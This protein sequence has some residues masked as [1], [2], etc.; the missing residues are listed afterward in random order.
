MPPRKKERDFE[1]KKTDQQA[2]QIG[3]SPSRQRKTFLKTGRKKRVP[4]YYGGRGR[5]NISLEDQGQKKPASISSPIGKKRCGKRKTVANAFAEQQ[6]FL[7]N[8]RK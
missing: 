8:K 4:L 6:R 3:G 1:K 7:S 2:G 5:E